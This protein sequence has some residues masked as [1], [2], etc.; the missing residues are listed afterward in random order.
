MHWNLIADDK[1]SC[2]MYWDCISYDK[3]TC[4]IQKKYKYNA[5]GLHC[6]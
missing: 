1:H 3:H 6:L 5:V 2:A 4:A